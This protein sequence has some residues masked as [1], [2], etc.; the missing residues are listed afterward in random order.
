MFR[1]ALLLQGYVKG[2]TREMLPRNRKLQSLDS[3]MV[4]KMGIFTDCLC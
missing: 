2:E 3:E 1:G 4:D